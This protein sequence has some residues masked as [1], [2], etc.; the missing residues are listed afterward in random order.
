M[1]ESVGLWAGTAASAGGGGFSP[2]V[3]AA[4]GSAAG[5]FTGGFINAAGNGRNPL[6]GGL[7]GAGIGATIG[8]LIGA[9]IE[10]GPT[11]N[12]GEG[13]HTVHG[14]PSREWSGPVPEDL[15]LENPTG[16]SIRG[17]DS[18]GEGHYGAARFRNGIRYGH[19]GTDFLGDA[20]QEV[21][22]PV[23]GNRGVERFGGVGNSRSVYL[24]TGVR[25]TDTLNRF[26]VTY[27]HI[28]PKTL[29]VLNPAQ[30][31]YTGMS[32][33]VHVQLEQNIGGHFYPVNA[34]PF[35]RGYQ[36]P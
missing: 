9:A 24:D 28:D 20:G 25:A 29:T 21:S 23:V 27:L 30:Y 5:G 32:P 2:A 26:R 8:F 7:T 4:I 11:S 17:M 22:V 1:G 36:F 16:G 34:T 33:H 3:A 19:E 35:I 6:V 15:V 13:G 14:G 12:F 10:Y 31:G 18:Y